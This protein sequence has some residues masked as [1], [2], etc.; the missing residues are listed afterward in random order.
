MRQCYVVRINIYPVLQWVSIYWFSR[1]GPA[2]S[3]RIYYEAFSSGQIFASPYIKVPSG[4]SIFPKEILRYPKLWEL[5]DDL[6]TYSSSDLNY[7]SG[8]A[9]RWETLFTFL[10]T[11]REVI[12][13][14]M[15]F[16]NY[17]WMTLGRCS[18]L[19]DLRLELS[20]A[21]VATPSPEY[22]LP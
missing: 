1:P 20:L 21:R 6:W 5:T 16:P 2:A 19:E 9:A 14:L 3:I 17:W 13:L 7:R 8:G 15:K 11:W 18:E 12:L 4:I 10:N 22:S